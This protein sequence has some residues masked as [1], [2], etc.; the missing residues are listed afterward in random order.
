MRQEPV[1]MDKVQAEKVVTEIMNKQIEAK[2][3]ALS[4]AASKL[5]SLFKK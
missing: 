1:P 2:P 5:K 4:N 3:Q